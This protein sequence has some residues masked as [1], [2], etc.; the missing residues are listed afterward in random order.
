MSLLPKGTQIVVATHNPGKLSEIQ[1]LLHP[2][3]LAA[4]S[5]ASLGLPEP[6]ETA[7]S[8][9][10]NAILK[11]VAA[12][13][14]SG[15]PALSDDSGL[16]VDSLGGA[17]GIYSA[18]WAGP[19]KDFGLAMQKVESEL[20]GNPDRRAHFICALCLAFPSGQQQV[21]E[22]RIDGNLVW[23]PRGSKGFGYDAMFV[24]ENKIHTFG[25]IEPDEKHAMSHRAKAFKLFLEALA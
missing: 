19:T 16:C 15:L 11:A 21:F 8:F 1:D 3:G 23:P 22:G 17:P 14:A 12:A 6:D 25:E 7:D 4:V 24:P 2:L 18:R 9:A 20:A 5:A 10:G 13:K